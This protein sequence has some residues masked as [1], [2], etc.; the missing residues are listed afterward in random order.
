MN[1]RGG[2]RDIGFYLLI[3]VILFMTVFAMRGGFDAPEQITYGEIRTLL[4]Q[5]QIGRASCRERVYVLV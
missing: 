5:E 2:I 4:E 3:A 1:Y